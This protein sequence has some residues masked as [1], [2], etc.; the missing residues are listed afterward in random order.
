MSLIFKKRGIIIFRQKKQADLFL[1]FLT[2]QGILPIKAKSALKLKAK[3]RGISELFDLADWELIKSKEIWILVGGKLFK[4][5]L[6][7]R[8]SLKKTLL[9]KAL[10]EQTLLLA[11][12]KETKQ[13][14][15]FWL[16]TIAK[17]KQISE[18]KLIIYFA[19]LSARLL[20]MEGYINIKEGTSILSPKINLSFTRDLINLPF[21]VLK[22]K[23][24][25]LEQY[26]SFVEEIIVYF[27]Q[28]KLKATTFFLE[29]F[30][31]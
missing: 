6:Y 27:S 1:Q 24:Y 5:P 29:K 9:L 18:D 22:R 17:L 8:K 26:S 30:A 21:F 10:A 20:A 4:R 14:F 19:F 13:V 16:N 28:N 12:D 25:S 15:N 31:S 2:N 23:N 3:L 11:R 7:L